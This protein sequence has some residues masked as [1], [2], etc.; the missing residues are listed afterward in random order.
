MSSLYCLFSDFECRLWPVKAISVK[1]IQSKVLLFFIGLSMFK[2]A[3]FRQ[4]SQFRDPLAS[5]PLVNS[6]LSKVSFF[7]R[8]IDLKCLWRS[9]FCGLMCAPGVGPGSRATLYPHPFSQPGRE[10]AMLSSLFY[11][12]TM[13]MSFYCTIFSWAWA[14]LVVVLWQHLCM[15]VP[16]SKRLKND[17]LYSSIM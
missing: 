3:F 2:I 10:G 4:T 9:I 7:L 17:T 15:R 14:T 12:F 8:D 5:G 16:T 1:V 6:C 11:D 13:T